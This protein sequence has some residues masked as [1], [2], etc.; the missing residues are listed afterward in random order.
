MARPDIKNTRRDQILDAFE[1]CV[2]RYGIEGA[3]LAKTAEQ[4]NLAR[5]LV[6]HNVG[7]RNALID[8]LVERFLKRSN[9]VMDNFIA[10]LPTENRTRAAIEFLFDPK[11]TDPHLVQVSYAL[12]THAQEN[13]KL[14]ITM[15]TWMEEFIARMDDLIAQDFPNAEPTKVTAVASGITGIY[16]NVE[17]MYG[18]GNVERLIA[19]SKKA[20]FILLESLEKS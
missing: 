16:F 4:A 9:D 13:T 8:A 17:T 20:A 18:L 19:C 6:R 5:P 7:N 14:A 11:H 10:S 3:T 1:T 15:Q 2:A 12:I